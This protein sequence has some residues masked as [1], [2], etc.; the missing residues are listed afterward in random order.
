MIQRRFLQYKGKKRV[1]GIQFHYKQYCNI[2]KA[3]LTLKLNNKEPRQIKAE[4]SIV[5]ELQLLT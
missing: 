5:K 2:V 4:I 3:R 1:R